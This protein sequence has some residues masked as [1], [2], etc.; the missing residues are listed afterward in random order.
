MV[1]TILMR[2]SYNKVCLF[3]ICYPTDILF[4]TRI[5]IICASL[6]SKNDLLIITHKETNNQVNKTQT[7]QRHGWLVRR[8][9]HNYLQSGVGSLVTPILTQYQGIDNSLV[10]NIDISIYNKFNIYFLIDGVHIIL[11]IIILILN[12]LYIDFIFKIVLT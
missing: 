5:M 11:I 2:C 6:T 9:S 12:L 10:H 4:N 8:L 1:E 3:N 7:R